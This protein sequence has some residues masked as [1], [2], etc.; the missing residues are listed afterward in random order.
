MPAGRASLQVEEP[1]RAGPA[2]SGGVEKWKIAAG[3]GIIGL[4]L[5]IVIVVK[6]QGKGGGPGDRGGDD[7]GGG[8]DVVIDPAVDAE[9]IIWTYH[10]GELLPY[11]ELCKETIEQHRGDFKFNFLNSKGDVLQHISE[12][13]LPKD[14]DDLKPRYKRD[15]AIN[16]LL[17]RHGG[18]A[19][20]INTIMFRSF[21]EWWDHDIDKND[22]A[23]KGFYY[24]SRAE[25]ATWFMMVGDKGTT[26]MQTAVERQKNLSGNEPAGCMEKDKEADLCYGSSVVSYALCTYKSEYCKCYKDETEGCELNNIKSKDADAVYDLPDPRL[27][28]QSELAKDKLPK[29]DLWEP[30]S[31]TLQ[32]D[33]NSRTEGWAN[34]MR[35]FDDEVPFITL[36]APTSRIEEMASK[37]RADLLNV[38]SAGDTYFYMWLCLAKHKGIRSDC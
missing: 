22:M 27:T 37:S 2:P 18:V 35:R 30:M 3:G 9:Q 21:N 1:P 23:F 16:A 8:D 5:V 38:D 34:F 25:T 26:I 20:D 17:A 11:Q 36:Q 14:W 28:V 13:D 6:A 4:I 32:E 29:E 12:E 7:A 10:D 15:T 19:L 33:A 31:S 24:K